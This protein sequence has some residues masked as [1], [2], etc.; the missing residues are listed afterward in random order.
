[1]KLDEVRI[2]CPDVLWFHDVFIP[3]KVFVLES[4]RQ[5]TQY[6]NMM[7]IKNKIKS[8]DV[9]ES[10]PSFYTN[11]ALESSELG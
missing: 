9:K 7:K 8:N 11:H 4:I 10:N 1:M 2:L 5:L 3:E 6:Y